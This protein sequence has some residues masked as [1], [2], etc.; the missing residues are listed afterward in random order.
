[1]LHQTKDPDLTPVEENEEDSEDAL[2]KTNNFLATLFTFGISDNIRTVR[3]TSL[4]GNIILICLFPFF[5]WLT[6]TFFKYMS[7]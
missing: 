1:M 6:I 3:E 2:D 4:I 5:L 7:S